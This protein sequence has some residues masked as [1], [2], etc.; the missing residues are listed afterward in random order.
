MT[1]Q[2]KPYKGRDAEAVIA[3]ALTLYEEEGLEITEIAP[4]LDVPARTIHRW[5][6]TNA[7]DRWRE[8]QQARALAD[9]EEARTA[10]DTASATL[11]RL[12]AA[13]DEEGISDGAERNWRLAHAREV[14]KAADT[15]LDH[16]K[17]LL[18]RLLSRLYGQKPS[19][20]TGSGIS[21]VI[22]TNGPA[23]R[24]IEAEPNK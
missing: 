22:N 14:L 15:Q 3:Q 8:L 4:K 24:I 20:P 11:G 19:A 10:R 5:L 17:W 2:L 16:Q 6:A 18:E 1:G 12:Q 21:I 23:G 9:Y 7:A 13:L